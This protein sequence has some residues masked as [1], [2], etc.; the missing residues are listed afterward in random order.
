MMLFRCLKEMN[1]S[2]G[3]ALQI[4][5][6]SKR[7]CVEDAVTRLLKGQGEDV[8]ERLEEIIELGERVYE[9]C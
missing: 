5:M 8:S 3:A 1:Y 7:L 4:V 6:D 9:H 2:K